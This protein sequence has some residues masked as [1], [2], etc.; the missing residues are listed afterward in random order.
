MVAREVLTLK[1]VPTEDML[2]DALT[3][4]RWDL[5]RSLDTVLRM[6]SYAAECD[7]HNTARGRAKMRRDLEKKRAAETATARK[8]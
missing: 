8:V 3:K 6:G 4:A 5:K 7:G 1:W 2:A